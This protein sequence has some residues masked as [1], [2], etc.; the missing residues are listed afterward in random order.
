MNSNSFLYGKG[1]FST[2]AIR[3][4]KALLWNKHWARLRSNAGIIGIACEGFDQQELLIELEKRVKESSIN[5]GRARIT[6][7]D[8]RSSEIWPAEAPVEQPASLHIVVGKQ[9][10]IPENF[11]LTVSPH[12]TNSRS[13]LVGIKSCNYLEQIMS[14]DEAK[15][16]RFHEAVR[17]NENGFV[18]S[19]CMANVFWLR[20]GVMNT[21]SLETGSLAGTTREFVLENME[22]REVIAGIEELESADAIYLTSAGLG[23]VAVSEYSGRK[24]AN[25]PQQITELLNFN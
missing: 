11:K 16:R 2:V 25:P 20:D 1:I 18:T 21:P 19:A 15:A 8:E 7:F 9:R 3:D 14:L 23:V 13:P 22:C 10:Q 4:G 6:F 24:L 12:P 5:N 17:V